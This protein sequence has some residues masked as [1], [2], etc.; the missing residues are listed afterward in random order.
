M[1]VQER[2][3][4]KARELFMRYGFRSVSMDEIAA[5]LG[6]SKKTI[7]QFFTD[8]D[9]LVEIVVDQVIAENE[10]CCT[11]Q[12]HECKDAIHEV[13]L[14]VEQAGE[15]LSN[16]NPSLMYDLEKYHP[17]A[18][19]KFV[20]H[21]NKF[22]YELVKNNIERGK[23]EAIYREEIKS[24]IMS[25][26]RV[27]STFLLFDA[28]SF[29]KGKYTVLQLMEEITENFLYGLANTKGQKLIQKYKLQ[30]LKTQ[31]V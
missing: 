12:A 2:I 25:Q 1:D 7:Y 28:D 4:E 18:F 21:K 9:A 17:N 14:A 31:T 6:V 29:P 5:H 11:L 19:K 15:M 23:Q 10:K 30:R 8:K 24:D 26:F 3:I 22:F 27:A 20:S 13:F 16:M